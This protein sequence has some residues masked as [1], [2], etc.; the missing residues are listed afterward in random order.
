[1]FAIEISMRVFAHT[2]GTNR[3]AR[4]SQNA[5]AVSQA[6]AFDLLQNDPRF[7]NFH[8]FCKGLDSLENPIPPARSGLRGPRKEKTKHL[9]QFFNQQSPALEKSVRMAHPLQ[10][11]E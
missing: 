6:R 11:F 2:H 8:L 3:R 1:M 4:P 10:T 9:S 7:A 5:R